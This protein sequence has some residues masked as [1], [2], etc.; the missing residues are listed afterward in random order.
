MRKELL[1]AFLLLTGMWWWCPRAHGQGATPEIR[2]L[3]FSDG[4]LVLGMS[5]NGKWAVAYN[6]NDGEDSRGKVINTETGEYTLLPNHPKGDET[7]V[8]TTY[9]A[10]DVSDDGTMMV[11]C[12]QDNPAA[13]TE[14]TGWRLLPSPAG[15]GYGLAS[16]MTPDKRYAVGRC[17][18]NPSTQNETAVMWDLGTLS[19]VETPNL[20]TM[21]LAGENEDQVRFTAISADGRYV[22]G[23]TS[24]TTMGY[25]MVF[26]Y[27]REQASWSPIGFDYDEASGTFTPKAEGLRFIDQANFSPDGEWVGGSA[28]VVNADGSEYYAPYRCRTATGEFTLYNEVESRG[29]LAICI[30]NDGCLMGGTPHDSQLRS[31]MARCGNYWFALDDLFNQRYGIDFYALSGFEYTGSPIALSADGRTIA[32]F[33]AQ[34][35][36]YVMRMPETMTEAAEGINLLAGHEA[37]PADGTAFYSLSRVTLTFARDVR[38]LADG[39]A[40]V[41]TLD[42]E[43]V[44]NSLSIGVADNKRD[45]IIQFRGTV[46]EDGREYALTLPAGA[47]CVDGD[48]ERLSPE[49]TLR[50][51][52]RAN[53]PVTVKAASPAEGG[54]LAQIDAST[55]AVVAQ[56]DTQ[57]ALTDTARAALFQ[58]GSDA[59]VC[60]LEMLAEGDRVAIYPATTQYLYKGTSYAVRIFA[61][62]LTDASGFAANAETDIRYEGAYERTVSSTDSLVL[63]EDF[64]DGLNNMLLYDGDRLA[65][66]EEMAGWSFTDNMPWSLVSD[67]DNTADK[68][69]VSHSMYTPAGKSDDWM[70]TPQCFIRDDKYVLRFRSQSYLK[71]KTDRLKVIVYADETVYNTLTKEIV[72]KMRTEGRVVYD[73]VESPGRIDSILVGDWKDH[74]ISLAAYAGK[75]IYVAF[76]NENE[77]QSAIFVDDL[78]IE[79]ATDFNIVLS[80]NPTMVAQES[81]PVAGRVN[82]TS[83]E[84]TFQ[85]IHI[86]LLDAEYNVLQTIEEDGLSLKN[87]DTYPFAFEKPLALEAGKVNDFAIRVQMGEAADTMRTSIRNMAFEP[88]KRLV[89]EEFTGMDCPNCPQGILALERME[90]IYGERLIPVAYHTYPGDIYA[91]DFTNFVG[92]ELGLTGAPSAVINRGEVSYPMYRTTTNGEADYMFNS[93]DRS[94]WMDVAESEMA[95]YADADISI[96]ATYDAETGNVSV[97]YEI[98]YALDRTGLNVALQLLVTEDGLPGYQTN[99]LYNV[100]DPDLGEWGKGGDNASA[101]VAYT[102]NDVARAKADY[103]NYGDLLPVDVEAGKAYTGTLTL[104]QEQLRYVSDI[105]YS[106]AALLL[107]DANTGRVINAAH[108]AI[109]DPTWDDIQ[110]TEADAADVTVRAIEGGIRV[111]AEE[112]TASVYTV[113]GTLLATAHVS[114]EATLHTGAYRGIAIVEVR[115]GQSHVVRKVM[116]K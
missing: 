2:P 68:S 11:G 85:D 104:N 90:G 99:N 74:T 114:G 105:H 26:I 42:G 59:P 106:H 94:C 56:F 91:G 66:T 108:A 113:G 98:T 81:T 72:E 27:D 9:Y 101:T 107:L 69:A 83:E 61:G 63:S 1:A 40:A 80:L 111:A 51:T 30:D 20:P 102:F 78:T 75:H 6:E 46:L 5:D 32:A 115:T 70:C 88:A 103:A 77:D 33:L 92:T 17:Y 54:N 64:N 31:F 15:W 82:V 44:R 79:R 48:E 53:T 18:I 14:A 19:I 95:E 57:V 110:G 49:I 24:F 7:S 22:V 76:V 97:P 60:E 12:F 65:P 38:L 4:T 16:A 39:N 37:A 43:P 50:Y 89:V 23:H 13:Y 3:T 36:N 109:D 93:P 25:T 87:G 47:L 67:N 10:T 29:I 21:S 62:S 84:K 28:Y 45:V 58:I 116:M 35:N 34:G 100:A 96:T 86:S 8:T 52:G 71:D 73:E 55:H 112:G 41:L